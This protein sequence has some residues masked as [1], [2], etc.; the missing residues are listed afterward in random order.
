M[1]PIIENDNSPIVE[2]EV[3][4]EPVIPSGEE[5]ETVEELREKNKQLFARAKKAEGFDLV[6]GQWVKR[7]KPEPQTEVLPKKET[8]L[9]FKDQYALMDAKVPLEDVDEVTKAAKLLGVS[10]SDALKDT[11]VQAILEKRQTLRKTADATNAGASR[12]TTKKVTD[13]QIVSK[14]AK[15]EIPDANTEEAERLFWARRGG[16]K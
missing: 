16:K 7:A 4:T 1:D 15:G 9:T 3:V 11:A 13:E 8:D 14:A 12:P 2:A 6:D 10:V 5:P